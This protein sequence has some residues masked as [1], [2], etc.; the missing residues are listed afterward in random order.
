MN[1][2]VLLDQEI[3]DSDPNVACITMDNGTVT[4]K[5]HIYRAIYILQ[6]LLLVLLIN[7]RSYMEGLGILKEKEKKLCILDACTPSGH[8]SGSSS[9]HTT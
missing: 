7:M 6:C 9:F 5:V 8:G 4:K 2:V 1:K 3:Q